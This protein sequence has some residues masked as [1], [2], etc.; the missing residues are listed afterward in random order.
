VGHSDYGYELKHGAVV[1]TPVQG[2]QNDSHGATVKPHMKFAG[3]LS[4][5]SYN[6][7]SAALMDTQLVD[8]DE[9]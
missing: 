5:E 8:T 3:V 2:V 4:Q 1:L 9:W 6:E 7:I